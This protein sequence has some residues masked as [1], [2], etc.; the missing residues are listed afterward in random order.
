MTIGE[1]PNTPD[2]KH[3]LSYVSASVKEL[4]LVIQFDLADLD[5]GKG[6]FTLMKQPW[7]LAKWKEIT[8]KSQEISDPQYD[9]WATTYLENHDQVRLL[10]ARSSLECSS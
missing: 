9:A 7:D 5:H 1:L 8:R 2:L 10:R 3:I 4:D 6:R